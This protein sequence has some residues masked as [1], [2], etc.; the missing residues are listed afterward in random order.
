MIQAAKTVSK[1][2]RADS[3][4]HIEDLGNVREFVYPGEAGKKRTTV[5]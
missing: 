5:F 1:R 4:T 2:S 3:S